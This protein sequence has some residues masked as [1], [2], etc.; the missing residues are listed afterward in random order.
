MTKGYFGFRIGMHTVGFA[1]CRLFPIQ[2]TY[3]S[4]HRLKTVACPCLSLT[5]LTYALRYNNDLWVW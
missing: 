2:R 1:Q 3:V 4:H 5:A